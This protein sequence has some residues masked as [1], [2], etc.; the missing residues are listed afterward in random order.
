MI[1]RVLANCILFSIVFLLVACSE[2]LSSD[3][4]LRLN[5]ESALVGASD[6]P[7]GGLSVSVENGVVTISGSLEC[8]DCGGLRTPGQ[9][10]TVQQS[11]GAVVRA[12]PGVERVEFSLN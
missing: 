9:T 2:E 5:V 11:L 12:V 7:P 8:E 6:L 10:G 1:K 3:D 4:Q